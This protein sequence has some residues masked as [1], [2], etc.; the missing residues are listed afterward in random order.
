M[1]KKNWLA[2]GVVASSAVG[3]LLAKRKRW[4]ESARVDDVWR[5]LRVRVEAD[6][7]QVETFHPEMVRELPQLAQ[8]YLCHAIAEG[9]PLSRSVRLEMEGRI[10][11]GSSGI[12]LAMRGYELLVPP[13]GFV[14]KAEIGTGLLRLEGAD[15]YHQGNATL[16]FW[17][18]GLAPL[19]RADSTPDLARSAA[20]R[21]ALEA[22]WC[23]AVLLPQRGARWRSVDDKTLEVTLPFEGEEQSLLLEV[24]E[25]G[26]LLRAKMLR[27]GNAEAP[28]VWG[29]YL[30][31][32]APEEEAAFDGYTI[33]SRAMAGWH[34]GTPS[35]SPFFY[36]EIRHA[37][38]R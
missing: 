27:W 34:F 38:F 8:R 4:I 33:P 25:D 29:S 2:A 20:G 1:S 31:G 36:A 30:F 35:Y 7:W 24:A 11:L 9:T 6:A 16:C 3:V 26:R 23:P 32:M 19:V 10:S 17:L 28:D 37:D 13:S 22:L 12:W 14:W 18:Y 5:A 21:L 15:T